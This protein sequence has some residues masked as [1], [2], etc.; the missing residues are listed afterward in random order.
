[1]VGEEASDDLLDPSPLLGDWLMHPYCGPLRG[2]SLYRIKAA[3]MADDGLN[4]KT[5]GQRV[6]RYN[7]KPICD[8]ISIDKDN[9]M[10]IW[11]YKDRAQSVQPAVICLLKVALC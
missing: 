5:L 3:D 7:S 10:A 6:E 2:S 11:R 9:N 1:V 4:A 8:G